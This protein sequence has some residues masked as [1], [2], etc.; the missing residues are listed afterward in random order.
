MTLE[1]Y[2]SQVDSNTRLYIGSRTSFFFIGTKDE[3]KDFIKIENSYYNTFKSNYH[4]NLVS[5]ANIEKE[6]ESLNI[7]IGIETHE[8]KLKTLNEFLRVNESELN[9]RKLMLEFFKK[10]IETFKPFKKRKIIY[11]FNKVTM[12]DEMGIAI[13]I[14]GYE[15]GKYWTYQEYEQ[16]PNKKRTQED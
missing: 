9:Q 15:S 16:R 12:P 7:K 2:L 4:Q 11:I 5:I 14:E 8:K 13:K 10:A 6:I 3:T 1:E